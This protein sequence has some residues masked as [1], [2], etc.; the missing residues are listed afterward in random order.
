MIKV[1]VRKKYHDETIRHKIILGQT[2]CSCKDFDGNSVYGIIIGVSMINEEP[3][4]LVDS[5]KH[6]YNRNLADVF[7]IN[8]KFKV[9]K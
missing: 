8:G 7:S 4:L 9:V 6:I 1:I 3:Q 5:K 2:T